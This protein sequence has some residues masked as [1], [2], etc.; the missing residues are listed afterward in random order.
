ML[1][2]SEVKKQDTTV[3]S[4]QGRNVG[5]DPKSERSSCK[6]QNPRERTRSRR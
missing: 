6:G 5:D 2:D 1:E 3:I 4:N